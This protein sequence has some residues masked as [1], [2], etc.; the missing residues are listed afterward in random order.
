MSDARI[1]TVESGW[2]SRAEH[3]CLESEEIVVDRKLGGAKVGPSLTVGNALRGCET[4]LAV[5]EDHRLVVRSRGRRSG[6]EYLVDLRFVEGA[7]V[8]RMHIAWGCWLAGLAAAAAAV[9]LRWPEMLPAGVAWPRLEWQGTLALVT[10]AACLVALA[11]YR[12]YE[13]VR[14]LSAH[15]R[16]VLVELTGRLGCSRDAAPFSA[17]LSQRVAHAR[18]RAPQSRQQFLRDELREHRRLFEEG[19]LPGPLYEAGKQRI[20]KAHV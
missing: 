6:R 3:I 1:P 20:L 13:S 12:S 2:A 11:V 17:V 7:P 10:A 8:T 5:L 9:G 4:E 16:V 18:A 14:F 15:G 19:V